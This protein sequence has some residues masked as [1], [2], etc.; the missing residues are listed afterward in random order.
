MQTIEKTDY[1]YQTCNCFIDDKRATLV[2]GELL[3]EVYAPQAVIRELTLAQMNQTMV[4]KKA[5]Q[6][7]K[8]QPYTVKDALIVK[9]SFREIAFKEIRNNCRWH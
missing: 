5:I 8:I 9:T 3:D 2:I 4:D 7:D 6:A 1:K